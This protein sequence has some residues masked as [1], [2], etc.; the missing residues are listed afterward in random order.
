MTTTMN[1]RFEG[2]EAVFGGRKTKQDKGPASPDTGPSDICPQCGQLWG[3]E[4]GVKSRE[5]KH[6]WGPGPVQGAEPQ[7]L[8][9]GQLPGK[10]RE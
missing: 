3:R 7:H 5:G 8:R 2:F 6:L 4:A 1:C 10:E 9:R